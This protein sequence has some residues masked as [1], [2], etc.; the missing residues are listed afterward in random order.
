MLRADRNLANSMVVINKLTRRHVVLRS[1]FTI[2]HGK[3]QVQE[4]TVDAVNPEIQ[5]VY[6]E[7]SVVSEHAMKQI[8]RRPFNLHHELP[9][10]WVVLHDAQAFRV[11]I[12]GH[13]I[14]VDGQSM[15]LISREFM[16]LLGNSEGSLPS[17]AEFSTMHMMEVEQGMLPTC[18]PSDINCRKHG[19]APR[20]TSTTERSFLTKPRIRIMPHG[21][22]NLY[23]SQ[24]LVR[25]TAKSTRG[26]H[27]LNQ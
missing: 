2:I 21:R 12:V 7:E 9:A 1:T 15:S 25:I 24:L 16:E 23:Q 17:L 14:I 20:H 22:N 6:H 13:H 18:A 10:K 3:P 4:H 19:L 8:L 5:V 11:Y 27:S 26:L